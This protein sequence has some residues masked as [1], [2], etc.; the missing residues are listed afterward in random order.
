V[1]AE[2]RRRWER[3]R[4]IKFWFFFIGIFE[5]WEGRIEFELEF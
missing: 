4:I 1:E 5:C 3:W 2:R